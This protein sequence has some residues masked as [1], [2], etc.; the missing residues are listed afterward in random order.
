VSDLSGQLSSEIKERFNK[1]NNLNP[2][3]QILYQ[4]LSAEVKSASMEE[5]GKTRLRSGKVDAYI[6]LDKDILDGSGKVHFYTHKP[7]PSS[8]DTFWTVEKIIN[9]AVVDQ[10]CRLRNISSKLLS[11]IRT[12]SIER[13]EVGTAEDKQRLQSEAETVT[14]M[15]IPFFFMFLIYM[16]IVVIGQQMLSSVIEEKNSRIIEV[17]L[18]AA[19]PFELM[20]GKILGLAGIGFTVVGLWAA[21]AFGAARWQGLDIDISAELLFYFVVYYILGFLLFSSILAGV[22][23]I[24]NTLKETQGL[25]MPIMLIFIIPL[26]SWYKL[27]QSPDGALSRVLSFVP[28]VTPLVMILRISAGSNVGVLEIIAS[29]ILLAVAVLVMIWL[30]SKI[31]RIGILMYGKRP[32]LREI[33]QWLRQN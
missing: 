23:S 15:M 13:V 17:L 10:R 19:S 4:S 5:Q 14:R 8:L 2:T 3:R 27:V 12:V 22:G 29:I 16:G 18:S 30:A 1:H 24:C 33:F 21:A 6:V 26:I 9:S 20:A 28:P 11:E 32:S 31:F 25:M 7:K